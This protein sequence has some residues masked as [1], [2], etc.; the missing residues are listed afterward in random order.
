MCQKA[1]GG[2]IVAGMTVSREAFRFTKGEPKYYKSSPLAERG[3]CAN[4]GS[5]LNY[6]PLYPPWSEWLNVMVATFD[7]PKT[8]TPGWHL[9]VESQMPWLKIQDDLERVRSADSPHL[10]QAWASFDLPVP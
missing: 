6:R 5:S 1:T 8:F 4:C 3:F 2:Q 10:V 9:G 7:E